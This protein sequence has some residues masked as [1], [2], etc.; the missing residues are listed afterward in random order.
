MHELLAELAPAAEAFSLRRRPQF[1]DQLFGE[2]RIDV[3]GG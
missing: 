1:A 2:M 3:L